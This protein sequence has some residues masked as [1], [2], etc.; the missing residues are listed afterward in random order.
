MKKERKFGKNG[1][2]NFDGVLVAPQDNYE[3]KSQF[4]LAVRKYYEDRGDID[5]DNLYL[6][7][8][9]EEL[10]KHVYEVFVYG[11]ICPYVELN[12]SKKRFHYEVSSPTHNMIRAN[13]RGSILCWQFGEFFL[14]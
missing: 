9:I 4:V 2:E 13:K 7:F 14:K 3:N 12:D 6:P 11:C 5:M 8:T 10:S 1:I